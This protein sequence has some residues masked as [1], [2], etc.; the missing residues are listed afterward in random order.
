MCALCVKDDSG[1]PGIGAPTLFLNGTNWEDAKWFY[2]W[3]WPKQKGGAAAK[4]GPILSEEKVSHCGERMKGWSVDR[5]GKTGRSSS[6]WEGKGGEHRRTGASDFFGRKCPPLEAFEINSVFAFPCSWDRWRDWQHPVSNMPAHCSP[7]LPVWPYSPNFPARTHA[8]THKLSFTTQLSLVFTAVVYWPSYIPAT[9][10]L[11]WSLVTISRPKN[12]RT[13]LLNRVYSS[14]VAMGIRE[15]QLH[16]C[17]Y[18][19]LQFS[20]VWKCCPS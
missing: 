1:A 3:H 18:I 7:A 16:V 4:L 20:Q 9:S 15:W 11:D 2:T 17:F 8:N 10:D 12:A 14:F 13:C 19:S 5:E 6:E